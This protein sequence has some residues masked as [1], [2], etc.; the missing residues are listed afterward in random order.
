MER[1]AALPVKEYRIPGG[2]VVRPLA[3][4][5]EVEA[6]VALQRAVF[7]SKNMTVEWRARTLRHPDYVPELDLVVAA[8]DGRLAAFCI[9]WLNRHGEQ[10]TGQV[11][12]LGC[13]E[14]FRRYALGRVALAEGLRRLRE[15]GA[16]K[17]H[18]ETDN[19]RNTAMRLYESMGFQTLRDVLMYRKDVTK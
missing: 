8:P 4:G 6:Y 15:F 13:H 11:E 1:S 2:F 19:Y 17:I 14:D 10:V 9:C 12:P 16:E 18:V 3:G 5:S 7:G